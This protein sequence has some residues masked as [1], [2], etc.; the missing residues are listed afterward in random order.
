MD[1]EF[2]VDVLSG[3]R[4]GGRRIETSTD[5]IA[6]GLAGSLDDAIK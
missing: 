1:V 4:I 6:M 5:L 3:K 2:T